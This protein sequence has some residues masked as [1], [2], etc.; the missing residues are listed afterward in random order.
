MFSLQTIFSF[1][2][3]LSIDDVFLC[4]KCGYWF[5]KNIYSEYKNTIGEVE[6]Y[7]CLE[8][9]GLCMSRYFERGLYFRYGQGREVR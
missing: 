5:L 6:L 4:E 9:Q 3:N 1:A 7:L 2:S 8:C